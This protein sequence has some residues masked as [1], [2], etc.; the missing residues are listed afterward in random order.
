MGTHAI[1]CVRSMGPSL[2]SEWFF[3]LKNTVEGNIVL[4]LFL[5]LLYLLPRDMMNVSSCQFLNI[6]LPG[7]IWFLEYNFISVFTCLKKDTEVLESW[8]PSSG[9]ANLPHP[10]RF[11][12]GAVP[13]VSGARKREIMTVIKVL[14]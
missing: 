3:G 14:L 8:L 1:S 6:E 9:V 12:L 5:H 10:P 2:I 13:Y 4:V 7:C 11:Y